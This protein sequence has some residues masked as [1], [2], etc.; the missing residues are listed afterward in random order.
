[1]TTDEA[2]AREMAQAMADE[3]AAAV[4]RDPA[5]RDLAL[6]DAMDKGQM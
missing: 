1:L 6:L 2:E 4:R 5:H 3:V